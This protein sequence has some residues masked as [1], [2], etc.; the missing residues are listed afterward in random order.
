MSLSSPLVHNAV[1]HQSSPA[2]DLSFLFLDALGKN[3]IDWW[4]VAE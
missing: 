1:Q 2:A 3:N 4:I